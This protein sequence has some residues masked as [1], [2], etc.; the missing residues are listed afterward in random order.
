MKVKSVILRKMIIFTATMAII[1]TVDLVV[2]FFMFG[3]VADLAKSIDLVGTQRMRTILLS[4]YV[5]ESYQK[6]VYEKTADSGLLAQLQSDFAKELAQYDRILLGIRQGDP[7][8]GLKPISDSAILV[9]I[10]AWEELWTAYRAQ[11]VATMEALKAGGSDASSGKSIGL[12]KALAIKDAANQVVEALSQLT[13]RGSSLLQNLLLAIIVLVFVFSSGISFMIRHDLLPIGR[14]ME[15]LHAM[16]G[17]DFTTRTGIQGKNEIGILGENLDSTAETLQGFIGEVKSASAIVGESNEKLV[18]SMGQSSTAIE[19]M[20]ANI[21]SIHQSLERSSTV[22]QTA[23][24]AIMNLQE[25]T[26]DMKSYIEQQAASVNENTATIEE[27]V[28][29][30]RTVA[31][32]T[33]T[34][35]DLSSNL[36][37]VA[38]AGQGKIDASINAMATMEESS[39]RITESVLGISKIAASTNLLAMNAAIE[40]AHA[41]DAGAGFAV[42][43][44]EIRALAES[45]AREAKTIKQLMDGSVIN[46][47]HGAGMSREAGSAFAEIMKR[48]E[49]TVKISTEIASAMD[50]QRL[51]AQDMLKSIGKLQGLSGELQ[52]ATGRNVTAQEEVVTSVDQLQEVSLEILNASNEQQIGGQEIVQAMG[53]LREVAGKTRKTVLDLNQKVAS[54]TV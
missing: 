33:T 39:K 31:E 2:V 40:A 42:V 28:T 41:G 16:R 15:V 17:Q 25:S 23:A 19:E 43:A 45:S 21:S 11:L 26:G 9:K 38:L 44:Q 24:Q 34:A 4:S 49:E 27:L 48:V 35:R 30:I 14:I 36:Q 3:S 22:M 8:L 51:A 18:T 50:E 5:S 46:I 12:E 53:Q 37:S 20:M 7:D 52:G 54:F 10:V 47:K 6:L 1:I 32:S 29:S 13:V